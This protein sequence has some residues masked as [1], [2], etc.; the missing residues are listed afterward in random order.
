MV[1]V[2]QTDL[3]NTLQKYISTSELGF[4][5]NSTGKLEKGILFYLALFELEVLTD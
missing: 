5:C 1:K 2:S 4:I 3:H